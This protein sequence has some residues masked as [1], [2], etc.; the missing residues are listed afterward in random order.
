MESTRLTAKA[1]ILPMELVEPGDNIPAEI[2]DCLA[3]VYW[4]DDADVAA[5]LAGT[6]WWIICDVVFDGL[7][8]ARWEVGMIR[9]SD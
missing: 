9:G 5:T 2:A 3:G 4:T 6:K 1:P 8:P 7:H